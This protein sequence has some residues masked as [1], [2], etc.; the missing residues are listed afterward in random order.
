[1]SLTKLQQDWEDLGRLDPLWS[2]ITDHERKHGKWDLEEFFLTGEHEITHLIDYSTKKG[3][4]TGREAAL[5]FGCG[6]GR[7]SG[8]LAKRY[9]KVCCVDI[10]ESMVKKALELNDKLLNCEYIVNTEAHLSMLQ[11]DTFDLI[12]SNIVLQH[13]PT[14]EIIQSYI[15]EFIRVMKKGGLLVF[16]LPDNIPLAYKLRLRRRLYAFLK[17]FH[18]SERYLFS[19]LNL[20]PMIMNRIPEEK[21]RAFLK[22]RGAKLLEIIAF[23]ES[24]V[25]YR[26][27][28]VTK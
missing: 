18:F 22:D 11:D 19:K 1:M 26:V 6:V 21:V 12:Y 24:A 13:I 14:R 7:L 2:I 15:S 16:Q 17:A 25:D 20:Y 9:G 23:E 5:D 27:Y 28:Y 3:Y 4:V 8:A 10:S